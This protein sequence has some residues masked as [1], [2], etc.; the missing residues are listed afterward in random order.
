MHSVARFGRENGRT[1]SD[2]SYG[3]QQVWAKLDMPLEIRTLESV[4]FAA[5]KM[6]V[7]WGF[8]PKATWVDK[9]KQRLTCEKADVLAVSIVKGKILVK[10]D[11]GWEDYIF[12]T[13]H[14]DNK[15]WKE[16]LTSASEK[17]SKKM[18][19][20]NGVGNGRPAKQEIARSAE[21]P[22]QCIWDEFIVLCKNN[23][24][25]HSM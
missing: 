11:A 14:P 6:L 21:T 16:V 2:Q 24:S 8:D 3:G 19:P 22:V 4:L 25:P 7:D 20:S 13:D 12:S 1:D 23:K 17:L 9:E 5:K 15:F 18:Q 10:Y